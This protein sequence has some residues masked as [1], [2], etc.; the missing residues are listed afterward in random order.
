V[1]SEVLQCNEIDVG[2]PTLGAVLDPTEL[3][4][5]LTP[6]LS[7]AG[8][9]EANEVHV[10]QHHPGS[11]C[12]VRIVL[13]TAA[14]ERELI[15]KVYSTDR[16]DVYDVM[17]RLST[18]GFGPTQPFSIPRPLGYVSQL[19]LLLQEKVDGPLAKEIF[20]KGDNEARTMAAERCA[21]WLAQFHATEIQAGRT[22]KLIDQLPSMGEWADQIGAISKQLAVK[23]QLLLSELKT[24]VCNLDTAVVC[25]SHG[26]FTPLQIILG[27]SRTVTFDWDGHCYADPSRDVARFVIAMRRI[28]LGRLKS[29]R[30]LD[31][32]ADIFLRAYDAGA[33]PNWM[34][35]LPVYQA[36]SCLELAHRV[37]RHRHPQWPM[38]VDALVSEGL[39][40]LED[41]GVN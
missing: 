23:A 26:S 39:L 34:K 4:K 9:T 37:L 29:I 41:Y 35:N 40:V 7:Y 27:G 1:F 3:T 22:F 18:D 10:L 24:A 6:V 30:A 33:K 32:A 28:G 14:G 15:G 16:S 36:A 11:R 2:I 20:L 31:S 17:K 38:K 19:R 5:H 13:C 25:A 21:G 8:S 12:T